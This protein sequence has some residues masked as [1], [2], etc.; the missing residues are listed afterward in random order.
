MHMSAASPASGT[1]QLLKF[2][3]NQRFQSL[4]QEMV[5]RKGLREPPNT[6]LKKH[7]FFKAREDLLNS[8]LSSLRSVRLNRH[9]KMALRVAPMRSQTFGP[10]AQGKC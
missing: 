9:P 5:P 6:L 2:P 4:E 10:L 7:H 1:R 3:A 8:L